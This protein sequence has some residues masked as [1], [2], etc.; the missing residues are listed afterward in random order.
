MPSPRTCTCAHR[1]SLN[2]ELLARQKDLE[3]LQAKLIPQDIALLRIKVAEELEA[4]HHQ[5]VAELEGEIRKWETLYYQMRRVHEKEKT[6]ASLFREQVRAAIES[7][8]ALFEMEVADL[9]RQLE[10]ANARLSDTSAQEAVVQL[11]NDAAAWRAREK[12][13]LGEIDDLRRLH[14]GGMRG[15]DAELSGMLERLAKAE[16]ELAEVRADRHA[17]EVVHKK[18]LSTIHELQTEVN[19]L[20]ESSQDKAAT[21]ERV[22]AQ[23]AAKAKEMDEAR[24]LETR[25]HNMRR[26]ELEGRVKAERDRLN[27]ALTEAR[28]DQEAAK[29]AMAHAQERV[30]QALH[31]EQLARRDCDAAVKETLKQMGDLQHTHKIY[32]DEVAE[33]EAR[34]RTDL[35]QRGEDLAQKLGEVAKLQKQ[36]EA[37]ET[38]IHHLTNTVEEQRKR[39]GAQTKDLEDANA[40]CK[41]LQGQLVEEQ[42]RATELEHVSQTHVEGLAQVKEEYESLRAALEKQRRCVRLERI[43]PP[44]CTC[45]VSCRGS[46]INFG[47]YATCLGDGR[48]HT[49]AISALRSQHEDERTTISRAA[50]KQ[51]EG[52]RHKA[53]EALRREQRRSGKYVTIM[54]A[55]YAP[56][57]YTALFA[58]LTHTLLLLLLL[59]RSSPFAGNT[60]TSPQP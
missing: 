37:A 54:R 7:D 1:E 17:Q 31:D 47:W 44:V 3:D 18:A 51:V 57:E 29:R 21:L 46:N 36:L 27:A 34:A 10:E 16:R 14:D 6:E 12:T 58:S 42:A 11:Q 22:R 32:R 35:K 9:T 13:L 56:K 50:K 39:E 45:N 19:A 20:K 49:A 2:A 55:M 30:D 52:V 15:K 40:R 48:E 5:R 41:K 25:E 23:T 60:G 24:R 28:A 43:R 8:K 59:L 53:T 38:K 33:R 26:V 4:P